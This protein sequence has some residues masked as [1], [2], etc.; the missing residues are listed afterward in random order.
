[1]A[2]RKN[3]NDYFKQKQ[4]ER[5]YHESARK[6]GNIFH[7]FQDILLYVQSNSINILIFDYFFSYYKE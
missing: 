3:D 6:R 5:I 1:M 4:A 2:A 7:S